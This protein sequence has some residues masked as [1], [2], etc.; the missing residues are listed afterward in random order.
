VKQYQLYI[1]GRFVDPVDG[2]WMDTEDPFRMEPWARIPRGS[3]ADVD[4][5]VEAARRAA[6]DAAWRSI[7]ATSR[8]ALVRR[9]GDLV[10]THADPLAAIEVRD[11]GKLLS[12][13]R[14][15]LRYVPQW[16]HYFG[17]LAD[18]I[19]GSV[20]PFDKPGIFATTK[21]E[22]LGVVA[23]ITPWNSPL[24]ITAVK[25]APALAAG[26]T[27]VLKPSEHTSASALELAVL[28]HEAG[29]PPGVFNV[30]TGL[31]GEI[32]AA[33]TTHPDVAKI[34]FTGSDGN[35]QSVYESGARS[36][37]RITLEL[38]GKSANIVFADAAIDDAVAGAISGIFAAGGQTCVA[39]SRLLVQ[40]AIHDRYVDKLVAACATIRLGDPMDEETQMGPVATEAQYRKIL[41]YLE[42]AKSEG[43]RC[44]LGGAAARVSGSTARF[45]QPTI[46]T[47]VTNDMRIAR[48]EV[49][50]PV[51]SVIPFDD[52]DD[53]VR[54]AND[55]PYGLAAGIW[56]SDLN[57]ALCL[58]DRLDAGVVWVNT[59]RLLSFMAP[60]GG[61]G[62]SGLGYENGQ[63]SIHEFMQ[64]KTVLI[65]TGARTES[66]FTMR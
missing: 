45:V 21:Y 48:E 6:S 46:F 51:L 30:V 15:Q 9:L 27:V 20:L 34:S 16:F 66:A 19:E 12:E 4:R 64:R 24:F 57:R 22:P 62:R 8:G 52:E 18:K 32:G 2:R 49:F 3:P 59:Y 37:K 13:M 7:S 54:I 38:G 17:G 50:G 53:A 39:G 23:L 1:D 58:P 61:H 56:T 60:V 36:I 10:A 63:D 55:S 44:V 47:G 41:D 25:L 35:G 28:V 42:I 26:N 14:G 40:R 11:N 5:A 43:A 29:F 65:N 31:G 33:L